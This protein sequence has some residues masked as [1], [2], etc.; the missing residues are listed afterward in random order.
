MHESG[1]YSIETGAGALWSA[2]RSRAWPLLDGK[3][4]GD[5]E[6]TLEEA[7]A[8]AVD[9]GLPGA[10]PPDLNRQ[11]SEDRYHGRRGSCVDLI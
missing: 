8:R 6:I 9:L 5:E 11:S 7:S 10:A 2:D 3:P 4:D 1:A